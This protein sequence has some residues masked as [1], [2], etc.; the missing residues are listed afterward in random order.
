MTNIQN[1]E[2][3]MQ[4]GS[5]QEINANIKDIGFTEAQGY[6]IIAGFFL[7]VIFMIFCIKEIAKTYVTKSCAGCKRLKKAE[8]EITEL[9]R[10]EIA[11]DR[12]QKNI[13]NMLGSKLNDILDKING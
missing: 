8:K 11:I 12:K 9:K 4:S 7:L 13:E 3:V 5:T 1:F 6:C 2:N 10:F